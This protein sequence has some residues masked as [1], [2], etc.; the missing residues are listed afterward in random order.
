MRRERK[1]TKKCTNLHVT[2]CL[3]A[4]YSSSSECSS[5]VFVLCNLMLTNRWEQATVAGLSLR[6]PG[7]DPVHV[8]FM[9]D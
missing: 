4:S 1:E 6:R 2:W 9:V 3:T 8:R 5:F 7:F